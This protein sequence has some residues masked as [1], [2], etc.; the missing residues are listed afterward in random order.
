MKISTPLTALALVLTLPAAA[1]LADTG[2][3]HQMGG[4]PLQHFDAID[5]DK[6]GKITQDEI[7]AYRLAR[8]TEADTDKDG[9]LSVDELMAMQ[10]KA[11][12][13]H[14][15][16]RMAKMI[17][18]RDSD[19]DGNLSPEE[20]ATGPGNGR[21]F[22]MADADGDGALTPEEMEAMMA[23]MQEHGGRGGMKG[24]FGWMGQDN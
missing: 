14:R 10:D 21:G 23:A 7:A 17:S 9:K 19:G 18:K 15:Q 2:N 13:G 3:S 11:R 20:F 1:A 6:D 12:G 22:A 16:E 24:H 4:M 8:A 5:A